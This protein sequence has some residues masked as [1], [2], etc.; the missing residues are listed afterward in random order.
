MLKCKNLNKVLF[1]FIILLVSIS[2]ASAVDNS[3]DAHNGITLGES[4]TLT[5]SNGL[6]NVVSNRNSPGTFTD[7]QT[8]ID[9]AASGSTIDLDKDYVYNNATDSSSISINKKITINGKNFKIDGNKQSSILKITLSSTAPIVLNDIHFVNG[10]SDSGGSAICTKNGELIL[11]NCQFENNSAKIGGAIYT[12]Q[13]DSVITNCYF[14][15]NSANKDGGAI[16]NKYGDY[17]IKNSIFKNNNAKDDGY[18]GAIYLGDDKALVENTT[19]MNNIAMY[20]GAIYIKEDKCNVSKCKF[21]NNTARNYDDYD[22][23]GGAVYVS[24]DECEI[25]HSSF[26]N[27]HAEIGGAVV[28]TGDKNNLQNCSFDNN[29]AG[30][31]GSAVHWQSEDGTIQDNSFTN[32]NAEYTGTIYLA[33]GNVLVKNNDFINNTA[34]YAGAIKIHGS[35]NVIDNCRFINNSATRYCGGALSDVNMKYNNTVVSNS[36]FK[37]NTAN[38]YGGAISMSSINIINTTFDNNSANVGGALFV[39]NASVTNS[40][41]KDN[42]ADEGK[43]IY[44]L[45]KVILN[46]NNLDSNEVVNRLLNK[47]IEVI[48]NSHGNRY[49]IYTDNFYGFCVESYLGIPL[50]GIRDDELKVLRNSLNGEDISEYLKIF[51]YTFVNNETDLENSDLART[52]WIFSDGDFKNSNNTYVKKVLEL[53]NSGLRIPNVNASKLLKNG[54]IMFFNFSSM[55]SPSLTQ[56]SVLFKWRYANITEVVSKETLNKTI[57]INEIVEFKIT[58]K[59]TGNETIYNAFIKDDDYSNGLVYQGW[60][61]VK[62]NW[63]YNQTLK[64]WTLNN[65]LKSGECVSIILLFKAIQNGTLTNNVTS[66]FDNITLSNG[67]NKTIVYKP[68]IKVI[69]ITNNPIV[70]TGDK[71]RFT[72]KVTNTGDCKLNGVYVVESSYDGLIYDSFIGSDW[73]K[74]GNRFIY[75]KVLGVGETSS[76]VVSFKTFKSGEFTNVVVVGSNETPNGTA[77]NTTKV[78]TPKLSVVKI[79]NNKIVTLGQKCS[80][81]IIVRNTGD[82]KL[83]KVFVIEKSYKGLIYD[84]FIGSDWTKIGNK[85]IYKKVLG[86]GESAN[87][88]I[89]FKTTKVG[90]FTNVIMAGSNETDNTTV[91]NTTQVIKDNSSNGE[92]NQTPE[93]TDII[94]ETKLEKTGNPILMLI[95]VLLIIPLIK[96]KY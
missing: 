16:Y 79:S 86:V 72:I 96:R 22:G 61:N 35:N 60:K 90:N 76:F 56:N 67:T 40:T 1:L 42:T 41:F 28:S 30:Y 78:F 95:M 36:L 46:N 80:F 31:H 33:T 57:I 20:G 13:T 9:S 94:K 18:G 5:Y 85:F 48:D 69:K 10:H 11:N 27:N 12:Y 29:Y 3:T 39:I 26:N 75:K 93:K 64:K 92:N 49:F 23:Y 21:T 32:N 4:D 66:G 84:S 15:N 62:G 38:G 14:N 74:S 70:F 83:T 59:N 55:I 54:T 6:N 68:N 88:T 77:N 81:T 52:V 8:L 34:L 73:T 7:L 50:F 37:G 45:N 43:S 87:F 19:F 2:A 91:E 51:I 53:Y 89:F 24:G 44:A 65:P 58:L 47:K 25:L 63:T 82:Y 17:K 71:V